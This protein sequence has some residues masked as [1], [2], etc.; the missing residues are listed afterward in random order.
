MLAML[1]VGCQLVMAGAIAAEPDNA[2][3]VE[4]QQSPLNCASRPLTF[5]PGEREALLDFYRQQDSARIWQGARL[6]H[7]L[8]ELEQL[9]DDGLSP[10]AYHLADLRRL[11]R[12]SASDAQRSACRDVLAS[13]AYLQALRDLGWGRLDPASV[14]PTWHSQQTPPPS[15]PE[16]APAFAASGLDDLPATFERARPQLKAYR[17][18]RNAYARLRRQPLPS[19]PRIPDGPLLRPGKNDPRVPL[20][21]QRLIREGYLAAAKSAPRN[22]STPVNDRYEPRL[23]SAVEAFQ[24]S[25]LLQPDGVIGQGTLAELNIPPAARRD[26]VRLNLERLRWLAREMEPDMVLVDLA[27]ARVSYYRDGQ[28]QWQARTQVGRAE[29]PSPLLKSRITHL[30]LNPTWTV[31]PTIFRK[32]KLP[33]IQ[34]NLGYLAEN[35][36]RV[37]DTAGKELS[38]HAVDWNNPHGILL[39]QDAGPKSAL[40]VLAIRFPNP[41]S[42]Y[43][44]DTPSQQLFNKLPRV[45]SS[46]CVRVENV[47]QLYDY[48]LADAS[49]AERERIDAILASGKTKNANLPHAVTIL[50]AY[51]TAEADEHGRLQFRPD[52]YQHDAAILAALDT[53]RN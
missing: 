36:I 5:T 37:L 44:H 15:R 26:Q 24:R 52:I 51:W 23:V 3:Q 28:V 6:A 53:A 50:L 20:L 35:H 7:L 21:E 34:R 30:T 1:L 45:F 25:H 42:V 33:E 31:P 46:G 40:G 11:E 43:L 14:E 27:G 10:D 13:H 9:A 18:L 49:P 2:L 4:L 39:R 16:G 22:K 12:L 29:R 8:K 32:D 48:L 41:F 38:P 47:M 17:D 19:W